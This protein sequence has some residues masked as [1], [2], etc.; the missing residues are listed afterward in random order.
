M[1]KHNMYAPHGT[2][3]RRPHSEF[4]GLEVIVATELDEQGGM[5][6]RELQRLRVKVRHMW[7]A[8]DVLPAE[9]DVIYCDYVANLPHHLPWEPGASKAA[10]V[11]LLPQLG[12]IETDNLVY[13]APDA[14]LARPYTANSILA[15]LVMSRSQFRYEQR[16]RGK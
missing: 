4:E 2:G 9:A 12:A 10:L 5:L 1:R 11:V 14:V 7:P 13:S 15:S 3:E 16:M 6:V 8:P